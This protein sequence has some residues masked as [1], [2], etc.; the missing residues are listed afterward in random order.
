[1][2]IGNYEIKAGADLRWANLREANLCEADLRGANL[3]EADL[4]DAKFS[5]YQICPEEGAFAA[6][7][8]V[9][10]GVIKLLIPAKARRTSSI[11]GRKCRAEYV[12]VL[13]G[14]GVSLKGG[15]YKQGKIYRSNKYDD[16]PRVEC[17]NGVHFFMTKKEA[18]EYSI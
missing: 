13:R 4:E 15:V 10:S 1:M 12:K 11:V 7:K 2:K 6:W 9:D 14:N 8:K 3:C 5:P 18:E 17:A 16:D